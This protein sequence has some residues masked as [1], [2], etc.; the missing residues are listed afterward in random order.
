MKKAGLL[1]LT[2]LLLGVFASAQAGRTEAPKKREGHKGSS[3]KMQQETSRERSP[4][5][6]QLNGQ[7][8]AEQGRQQKLAKRQQKDARK[9]THKVQALR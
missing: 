5:E 8:K 6:K 7:L 3:H 2:G 4:R 9:N 1:F